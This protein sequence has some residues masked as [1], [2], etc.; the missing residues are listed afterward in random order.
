MILLLAVVRLCVYHTALAE[1]NCIAERMRC[2]DECTGAYG[3]CTCGE[4]AEQFN[5][6]DNTT[7]CCNASECEKDETGDI[8]CKKGTLLPLTTPCQGKCHTGRSRYITTQYKMCESMDQCIKIQYWQDNEAVDCN[9]RSD[10]KKMDVDVFSPIQWDKLTTCGIKHFPGVKCSGQGIGDDCLTMRSWCHDRVVWQCEELGGRT[11]LH[12]D[13]CS[14]RTFWSDLPCNSGKDEGTRCDGEY[15]GQC[16]YHQ[17]GAWWTL[18][19]ECKDYSGHGIIPLPKSGSCTVL[20]SFVIT[21]L[22]LFM[23]LLMLFSL[24]QT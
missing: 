15:P 16:Y 22:S 24:V 5:T 7:W 18:P 9:D 23:V 12:T 14:N 1:D 20:S 10:E 4:D 17:K 21:F 19:K 11:T 8:V 3:S 13:L 2:G 6:Y